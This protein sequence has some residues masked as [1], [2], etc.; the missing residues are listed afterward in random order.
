MSDTMLDRRQF[1]IDGAWVDPA[2]AN[3]FDV[4]DPSTEQTCAVISLGS[5]AATHRRVPRSEISLRLEL[6]A[7]PPATPSRFWR[8]AF[9]SR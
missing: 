6:K 1:Y 3:D 7:L 5:E 4:I 2:V 9:S 8:H